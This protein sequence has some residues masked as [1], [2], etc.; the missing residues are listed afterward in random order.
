MTTN[1]LQTQLTQLPAEVALPLLN[2]AF[3]AIEANPT[4]QVVAAQSAALSLSVL[5]ALPTLEG[6]AIKDIA[7]DAQSKI[8][9]A[10]TPKT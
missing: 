5:A 10:L 7:V 9:T 2:T 6:D 3:A 4:P 8:N 1:N